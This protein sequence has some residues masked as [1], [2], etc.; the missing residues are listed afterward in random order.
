MVVKTEVCKFS[1]NKIYPGKGIRVITKDGKLFIFSGKKAESF[2]RKK[3]K[4]LTVRWTVMWRRTNK[5][6]KDDKQKRK[7]RRKNKK[8]VKSIAGMDSEEIRRRQNQTEEERQALRDK[9][10]REM[11]EKQ[12]KNQKNKRRKNKK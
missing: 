2:F 6:M 12:K 9:I 5:K 7:R 3:V 11:K 4:G 1:E 8:V 10:V